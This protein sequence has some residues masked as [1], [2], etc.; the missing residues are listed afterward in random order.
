MDEDYTTVEQEPDRLDD[1]G[2][3]IP[4]LGIWVNAGYGRGSYACS[5]QPNGMMTLPDG[6]VRELG[7][8][9]GD[10]LDWDLNEEEGVV[11]VKVVRRQWET[12]DWLDTE[13]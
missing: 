3:P 1:N 5:I 7:I 9:V 13:E 10:D 12:P 11:Y 6:L 2:E 8:D 4:V